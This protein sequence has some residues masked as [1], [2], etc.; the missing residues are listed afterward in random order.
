MPLV[1]FRPGIDGE[2]RRRAA[3]SRQGG[4]RRHPGGRRMPGI[5]HLAV[6]YEESYMVAEGRTVEFT[7][8][9]EGDR[10]AQGSGDGDEKGGTIERLRQRQKRVGKTSGDGR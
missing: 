9:M 10:R 3:G 2:E 5:E 6:R 4:R 8:G 1:R 7:I